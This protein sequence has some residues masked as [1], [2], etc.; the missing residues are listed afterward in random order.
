MVIKVTYLDLTP[1][2]TDGN[3]PLNSVEKRVDEITKILDSEGYIEFEGIRCTSAQE[4]KSAYD[5]Y[6]KKLAEE[7]IA[8]EKSETKAETEGEKGDINDPI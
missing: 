8:E 5:N 3:I 1:K 2:E 6:E 7:T 4:L